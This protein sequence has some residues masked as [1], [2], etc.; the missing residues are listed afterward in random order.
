MSH[1]RAYGMVRN[2]VKQGVLVRPTSC[3]RCGIEPAPASDGRSRIQAHHHDYSRPLNVE[4]IC[5]KCHRAETPLPERMGAPV[6]GE[7]NGQSR[8]NAAAV[9]SVRR[10]RA[11]GHSYQSIA[12]RHG[13]DKHTVIRVVKGELWSHVK[14]SHE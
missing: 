1:Q 7:R 10:L 5:A 3:E 4:W 14:D 2:A 9:I 13:V 11:A 8:L 6:L 12:N